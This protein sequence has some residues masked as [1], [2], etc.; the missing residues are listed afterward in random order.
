MSA[1]R[2]F[3]LLLWQCLSSVIRALAIKNEHTSETSLLASVLRGGVQVE[4]QK[5]KKPHIWQIERTA[6]RRFTVLR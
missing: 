6:I 2:L 4:P 3:A 1:N 5:G